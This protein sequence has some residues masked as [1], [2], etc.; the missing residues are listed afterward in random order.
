MH[1]GC[2]GPPCVLFSK[3]LGKT[4]SMKSHHESQSQ[5]LCFLSG[6]GRK[7]G[8]VITWKDD[9]T[10]YMWRTRWIKSRF[11]VDIVMK[12]HLGKTFFSFW[13]LQGQPSSYMRTWKISLALI[14]RSPLKLMAMDVRVLSSL[15]RDGVSRWTG[16]WPNNF[17]TFLE[18][19]FYNLLGR[20]RV[21]R[22]FWKLDSLE[23]HGPSLREI[24]KL[25]A[26]H[27]DLG[28][29]ALT[30]YWLDRAGVEPQQPLLFVSYSSLSFLKPCHI[31]S[32]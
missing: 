30:M 28:M 15:R 3:S 4:I 12:L 7:K 8:S 21:F 27:N 13:H 11:P 32:R 24:L 29:T 23:W 16:T 14:L 10:T 20:L 31:I 2:E 17:A 18:M 5:S 6:W 22:I 26:P 1:A 25:V 19:F 9:A